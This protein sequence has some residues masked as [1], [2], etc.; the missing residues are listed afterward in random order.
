T[1]IIQQINSWSPT[2]TLRTNQTKKYC[3]ILGKIISNFHYHSS[4]INDSFF[5]PELITQE[6]ISNWKEK[7]QSLF[8]IAEKNIEPGFFNKKIFQDSFNLLKSNLNKFFENKG[9]NKL[10]STM[11]I[12]IHQ[13]LHLS[14]MITIKSTKQIDF[15]LFDFE[16]DPLLSNKEKLQKDPIFRD[17]AGICS[18]FHY[19]KF[20]ALKQQFEKESKKKKENF[21]EIYLKLLLNASNF[22]GN[23]NFHI[24]QLIQF[25]K[26][27]E[28][29]CQRTF[30][31]SYI[32]QLKYHKL[33]FNLDLTNK[34]DF[35]N[36]LKLFRIERLIKELYYE[37]VF[38]K[39]MI[40]IPIIGLLELN[41]ESY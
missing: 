36:Q 11:K 32:Q 41:K 20:N 4:R 15:I 10:L 1:D 31:E 13:D 25:A 7:I 5:R 6:A 26:Q 17:L 8:Q 30:L 3:E 19:I 12:K 24:S 21:A 16:G 33:T 28:Q 9:W 23:K 39:K 27:W 37:T 14:Q 2:Q 18:A 34:T 35:K 29:Y 38:R 40:I 22:S